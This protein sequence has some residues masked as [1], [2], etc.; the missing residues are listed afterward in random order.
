[1]FKSFAVVLCLLTPTR[2]SAHN[3]LESV[4][5]LTEG[6]VESVVARIEVFNV[7]EVLTDPSSESAILFFEEIAILLGD[8]TG[9]VVRVLWMYEAIRQGVVDSSGNAPDGLGWTFDERITLK[10]F[11]AVSAYLGRLQAWSELHLKE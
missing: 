4:P 1:M 8:E 9:D 5:P 7:D 11:P 3:W 10:D 2:L 6:Q